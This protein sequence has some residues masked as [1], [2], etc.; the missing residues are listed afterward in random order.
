M[1]VFNDGHAHLV[2][3]AAMLGALDELVGPNAAQ[4]RG[5]V[6]VWPVGD[7]SG[8]AQWSIEINDWSG[9]T[10][11]ARIGDHLVLTYGRLLRLSHAEYVEASSS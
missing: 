6:S 4:F 1:T 10:T 9:N 8:P 11:T 2:D 5:A 3:R 7:A